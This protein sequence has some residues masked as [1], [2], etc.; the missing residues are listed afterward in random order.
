MMRTREGRGR[1][2]WKGRGAGRGGGG[3]NI[4]LGRRS[5]KMIVK[6]EDEGTWVKR[7]ML[8]EVKERRETTDKAEE[9]EKERET[10]YRLYHR[11]FGF[12]PAASHKE[13][14]LIENP[15]DN[16]HCC[17]SAPVRRCSDHGIMQEPC[18]S[19]AELNA[20]SKCCTF[21]AHHFVGW[22]L[23]GHFSVNVTFKQQQFQ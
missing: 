22:R 9:K 20:E 12:S 4:H 23:W 19:T 14:A 1:Q 13:V 18:T 11:C 21:P 15:V 7:R 2:I 3:V 5:E 17:T 8:M 10:G 6:E 16:E